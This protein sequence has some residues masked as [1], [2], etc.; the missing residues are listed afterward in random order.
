MSNLYRSAISARLAKLPQ[1]PPS[2][3]DGEEGE[4]GDFVGSLPGGMGPP[5]MQVLLPREFSGT[6]LGCEG[7]RE[8]LE[9]VNAIQI[10]HVLR[11]LPPPFLQMQRKYPFR[12]PNW[13]RESIIP[14]QSSLM[15]L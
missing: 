5:A 2:D 15:A 4:A 3:E 11:F 6:H 1:L 13:M 9:R 10:P 8:T 14:R 12:H 7:L